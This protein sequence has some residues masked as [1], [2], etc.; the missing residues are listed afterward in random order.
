MSLLDKM[1][2]EDENMVQMDFFKIVNL[3][4]SFISEVLSISS[5]EDVIKNEL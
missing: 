5:L 3:S 1:K 2:I 4:A